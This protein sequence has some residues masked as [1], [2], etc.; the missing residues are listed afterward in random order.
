MPGT[1]SDSVRANG[2]GGGGGRG[3]VTVLVTRT[4]ARVPGHADHD[5]SAP[6]HCDLPP[7]QPRGQPSPSD[8]APPGRG[9]AYRRHG[10]RRRLRYLPRRVAGGPGPRPHWRRSLPVTQGSRRRARRRLDRHGPVTV[11]SYESNLRHWRTVP[12][13]SRVKLLARDLKPWLCDCGQVGHVLGHRLGSWPQ[14]RSRGANVTH[15]NYFWASS[16]QP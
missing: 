5:A 1:D 8:K 3:T 11:D 4:R 12:S 15:L 10:S 13:E 2:G 16:W 14:H 6:S 9:A 7:G